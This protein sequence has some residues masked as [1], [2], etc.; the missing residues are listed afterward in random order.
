VFVGKSGRRLKILRT[1]NG[2]EYINRAM[3]EFMK[4][5]GICHQTTVAYTSEQNGVAEKCNGDYNGES[6]YYD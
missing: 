6:T 5:N 1:D 4:K 2:K 3:N